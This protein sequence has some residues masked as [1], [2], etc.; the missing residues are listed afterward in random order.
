MQYDQSMQ[1]AP[2]FAVIVLL[3]LIGFLMNHAVLLVERRYCFWAQRASAS[4]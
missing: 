2:L 3:G 4:A 1:I